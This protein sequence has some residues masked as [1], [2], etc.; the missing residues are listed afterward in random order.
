[1]FGLNIPYYK[2]E[3]GELNGANN[4][5]YPFRKTE[6]DFFAKHHKNH[7]RTMEGVVD[8]KSHYSKYQ[9]DHVTS[10]MNQLQN[11]NPTNKIHTYFEESES[12]RTLHQKDQRPRF[13]TVIGKDTE[14]VDKIDF[15][16]KKE[17]PLVP[18]SHSHK[19]DI[20]NK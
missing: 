5:H 6:V 3:I 4:Y 8:P 14:I 10:S 20:W 12:H 13:E 1:M 15:M 9:H 18:F 17:T 19:L 16:K 2:D 11:F 7:F